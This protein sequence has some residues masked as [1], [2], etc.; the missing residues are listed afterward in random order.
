MRS[1]SAS[2]FVRATP[3]EVTRRL[4]P[5]TLIEYEGT[6]TV[7]DVQETDEG[8][9]VTARATGIQVMLEFEDREDGFRYAQQGAAGPFEAM[10][11]TLRV[12]PENEGS[13]VEIES[14]V[15]LGV[16]PAVLT[17]RIAAW[18]RR[19]ELRRALRRLAADFE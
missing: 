3:A 5:A 11:T 15:S 19:G 4:D 7:H 9:I 12:R 14:H 18:K 6:F 13:R 8:A 10:E 16:P 2:Q 17:D 1:A